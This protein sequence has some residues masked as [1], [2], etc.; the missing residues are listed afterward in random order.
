MPEFPSSTSWYDPSLKNHI[1]SAY[2]MFSSFQFAIVSILPRIT[3]MYEALL[4]QS[5]IRVEIERL[6][7]IDARNPSG[8]TNLES[9]IGGDEMG[10]GGLEIELRNLFF[11]FPAKPTRKALDDVSRG[12]PAGKLVALIGGKL[13]PVFLS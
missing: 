9:S 5:R 10:R 11:S 8:I 12:I 13:E 4:A 3:S 2:L 6:S 1:A 7:P